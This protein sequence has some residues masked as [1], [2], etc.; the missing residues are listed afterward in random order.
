MLVAAVLRRLEGVTVVVH[1]AFVLTLLVSLVAGAYVLTVGA[2]AMV[3]PDL[4]RFGA[5][6]VAAVVALAVH[7][8]ARVQS[9][10]DRLMHG[11]RRDPFSAVTRLAEHAHRAP[12]LD[13]VLGAV[14]TS[15]AASLRVPWVRVEAFGAHADHAAGSGPDAD[16]AGSVRVPLLAG[17]RE[18][19]SLVVAPQ[20]GRRLRRDEQRILGELGRHGGLAVDSVRLAAEVAEHH[21][22]VLAAREE[23]RRRLGRELHDGLGPTVA[24]LSMQLGALRPMVHTDPDAVVARLA[25][26]EES[27]AA[28]LADIRRVAHELRPPVLDQ[29]GLGR[30]VLSVAESLD[31]VVV[32]GVVEHGPLPAAVELAAYRVMAEA[33]SNVARHSGSRACARGPADRRIPGGRRRR[34][35]RTRFVRDSAGPRAGDH[36]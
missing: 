20:P 25:R 17:D 22:E 16:G 29:A 1:H 34:R 10:V 13:E 35:A 21:R 19:G 11:D 2:L 31:L 33:L 30:A 3:G 24:G 15:V 36:A 9:W 27:S 28:A 6:V 26:L 4:S 12:S 8:P 7:P 18:I 23:E 5:G 32:D 14:A